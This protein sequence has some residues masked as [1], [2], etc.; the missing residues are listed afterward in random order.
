V[1]ALGPR[2][3]RCRFPLDGPW[4]CLCAEVPRIRAPFRLVLLRHV[5]ERERLS[6]TGQWAALAVEGTRVVDHGFPGP[7]TDDALLTSEGAALL[8]PAPHAAPPP[9]PPPRVLIVP[10]GS[11]TQARRMVQR[12]PALRTLPRLALP[13]PPPGLRLRRPRV[14]G[15]MSTL[16]AVAEA[17]A[18]VGARDASDRLLALHAAGVERVLRLKGT[19]TEAA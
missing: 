17:L 7:P 10:D 4:P 13:A 1:Q 5:S 14:E 12:L 19:W 16:E 18:A 6:N 15:G 2:C 9:W 3:P 11:W 8:F